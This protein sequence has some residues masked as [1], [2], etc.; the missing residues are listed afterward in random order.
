GG[1]EPAETTAAAETT[2]GTPKTD[3]RVRQQQAENIDRIIKVYG[4]TEPARTVTLKAETGGRV[5]R[6]NAARGA[7]V[8]R[9]ATL[10]TLD[11]RDRQAQLERARAEAEAAR[12]TY[13]AELK[14][15]HESFAS[16][17]RL[18]QAKAAHDAARAELK[19]IEVDLASTRVL[20]P[21]DGAL[22]ER[23]VEEGDYVAIGDPVATFVEVDTLLITGSISETERA[24]LALGNAANAKLVTGQQVTGT[25]SYIAPVADEATRTFDI[26][27]TVANP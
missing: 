7:W 8:K 13:E 1:G 5:A 15:Q 25:V 21:F 14:L 11:V 10:F 2:T 9:G 22:Q 27:I 20:A 3:V 16:A 6:T 17:T 18:A 26:E 12:L 23:L 24:H 19:R 4:R